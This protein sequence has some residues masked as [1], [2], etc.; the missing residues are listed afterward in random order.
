ME[1]PDDVLKII[2]EYSMPITRPDWRKG[3]Y[4]NRFPYKIFDKYFTFKYL[5]NV[6]IRIH[7]GTRINIYQNLLMTELIMLISEQ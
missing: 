6:C 7:I 4:Y 2:K 1:L 3:C 5:L